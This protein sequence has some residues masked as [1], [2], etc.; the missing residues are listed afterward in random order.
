MATRRFHHD[1]IF[2]KFSSNNKEN[3]HD[4]SVLNNLNIDEDVMKKYTEP[5]EK[6]NNK[7][8][9]HDTS[10]FKLKN[11]NISQDVMKKYEELEKKVQVYLKQFEDAHGCYII[12]LEEC[13]TELRIIADEVDEFHKAAIITNITGSTFGIAGGITTIVGLALA[14]VTFG[15]SLI[16]TGVGIGVAA[17]GGLTGATASIADNVNIKLKCG[18][19]EAIIKEI[20]DNMKKMQEVLSKLDI[21]LDQM[22]CLIGVK[23]ID[24]ARLG[25]RGVFAAAEVAR[26]FQLVK[27]SA[28]AARGAQLAGRVAQASAAVSGVLAALFIVVDVAFVVKG[29]IDLNK[30]GKAE[31]AKKI[32]ELADELE[33]E[34]KK[35]QGMWEDYK[36]SSDKP[37]FFKS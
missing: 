21:L 32:R 29:A 7:E 28:T 10:K 27:L 24:I 25:A 31:Q 14:P 8:H 23:D 19:V 22:K 26:L 17:A 2:R 3:N 35:M 4:K 33:A 34:F 9:N 6:G 30:G 18:R 13:I 12:H 16:I 20:N 37:H 11:V 1:D 5:E 15:T 36:N